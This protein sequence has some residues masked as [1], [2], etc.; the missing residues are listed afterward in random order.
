[1]YHLHEDGIETLKGGKEGRR[2]RRM[3]ERKRATMGGE[4]S[5]YHGEE[6]GR[7]GQGIEITVGL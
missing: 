4:E 6:G 3:H 2:E 5:C 1:M 7:E